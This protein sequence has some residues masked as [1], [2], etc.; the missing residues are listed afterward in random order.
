MRS[1]EAMALSD[2][3][4]TYFELEQ[5]ALEHSLESH[6]HLEHGKKQSASTSP[7]KPSGNMA[8]NNSLTSTISSEASASLS[9]SLLEKTICIYFAPQLVSPFRRRMSLRFRPRVPMLPAKR[10]SQSR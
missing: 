6:F 8:T 10:G 9:V 7:Y 2:V 1:N 4:A 5:A 3:D